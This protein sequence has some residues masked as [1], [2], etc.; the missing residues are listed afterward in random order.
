MCEATTRELGIDA[1]RVNVNGSGCSL[2]HPIAAT[3]GCMVTT[4]VHGLGHRGGGIGVA[5]GRRRWHGICLGAG[6]RR[7]LTL[8]S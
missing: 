6:G 4:L 2:G 8:T 1:E 5:H 7:A 3:G